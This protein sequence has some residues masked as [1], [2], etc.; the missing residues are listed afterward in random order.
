[1]IGGYSLPISYLILYHFHT[2]K[3]SEKC[4]LHK[5]LEQF[6]K[7]IFKSK[8]TYCVV[9]LLI[10]TS[11]AVADT[12]EETAEA[13][14]AAEPKKSPIKVGGAMRVNYVY[15]TYGDEDNPHP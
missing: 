10:V 4:S 2:N 5:G 7:I 8:T 1:M 13:V 3:T 14:E 11:F 9:L 12:T 15:G 6:L